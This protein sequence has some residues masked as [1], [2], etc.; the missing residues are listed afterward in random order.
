MIFHDSSV[1]SIQHHFFRQLSHLI[2][3]SPRLPSHMWQVPV[4]HQ[5]SDNHIRLLRVLSNEEETN[6]KNL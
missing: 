1:K 4:M 6:I 2:Q 3:H 5:L